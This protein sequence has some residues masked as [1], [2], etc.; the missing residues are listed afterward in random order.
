MVALNGGPVSLGTGA[1]VIPGLTDQPRPIRDIPT[2]CGSVPFSDF[3]PAC[4]PYSEAEL[5]ND[6]TQSLSKIR[7]VNP[8]LAARTQ[9]QIYK[10]WDAYCKLTPEACGETKA[11]WSNPWWSRIVGPGTVVGVKKGEIGRAHV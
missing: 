1:W 3:P 7:K 4:Q 5:R 2:W 6:V 11:F 9:A 8:E 10:D